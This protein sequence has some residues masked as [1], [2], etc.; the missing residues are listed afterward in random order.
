MDSDN[1]WK[2]IIKEHGRRLKALE[3]SKVE[4]AE[5]KGRFYAGIGVMVFLITLATNLLATWWNRPPQD[6]TVKETLERIE[7]RQLA[8]EAAMEA[9]HR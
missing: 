2:E 9:K 5:I 3:D 4:M 8:D 6:V 1:G 7:R